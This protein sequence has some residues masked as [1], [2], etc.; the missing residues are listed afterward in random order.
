MKIWKVVFFF[1]QLYIVGRRICCEKYAAVPALISVLSPALHGA[2]PP[3]PEKSFLFC[4]STGMACTVTIYFFFWW[5]WWGGG[6]EI[7][8]HGLRSEFL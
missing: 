6:R 3:C 2:F 8:T 5:W 7:G 4:F 1:F